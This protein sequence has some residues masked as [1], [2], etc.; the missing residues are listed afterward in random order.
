MCLYDADVSVVVHFGI[1]VAKLKAV[2]ND[3]DHS[4][5]LEVQKKVEIQF[6]ACWVTH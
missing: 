1:S 2:A 6:K 3:I 4:A 5:Q